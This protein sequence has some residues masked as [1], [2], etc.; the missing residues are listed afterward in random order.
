MMLAHPQSTYAFNTSV[1]DADTLVDQSGIGI[2]NTW[3]Y[4]RMAPVG[5]DKDI[6]LNS[7]D[8]VTAINPLYISGSTDSWIT[9][10]LWDRLMRIGPDGLP[11][12]WAATGYEWLDETTVKVTL[13]DGM[14]WHDGMPVTPEDVKFSFEAAGSGEAP[15]YSPFVTAME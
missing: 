10:L 5:D 14:T 2:R 9:E 7:S 13:R 1:W 4:I 12:P 6:I 3:S 11:Q 8:N 15:M